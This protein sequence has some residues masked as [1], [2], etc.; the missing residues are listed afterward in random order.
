ML[1]VMWPVS[2]LSVEVRTGAG[3]RGADE[4]GRGTERSDER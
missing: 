1:P 4:G 2:V 3:D